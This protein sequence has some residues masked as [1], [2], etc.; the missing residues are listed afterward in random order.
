MCAGELVNQCWPD[1]AFE[2]M[3]VAVLHRPGGLSVADRQYSMELSRRFQ[4]AGKPGAIAGVLG[5]A[6]EPEIAERL[7]SKDKTVSLVAV[8]LSSS[9]VTDVARGGRVAQAS[10]MRLVFRLPKVSRFTGRA[11]Q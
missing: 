4:G 7:E 2:A 8:T 9:F 1:Q 3:A 11:T 6:S 5:P 10:R